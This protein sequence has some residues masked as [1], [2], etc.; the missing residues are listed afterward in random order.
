[1][2]VLLKHYCRL[3]VLAVLIIGF[4]CRV[5]AQ[6][7]SARNPIIYA[8]VPDASMIR[9]GGSYYM[10]ST[11]M[12]MVPGVPIMKSNDLVNWKLVGYAYDTLSNT[13]DF[14]LVGGKKSSVFACVSIAYCT[15]F[16]FT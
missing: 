4:L 7:S 10:S 13:D 1:M 9:V 5:S 15:S 12:H 2:N 3:F 14:N 8:D 11:T 6:P 16:Q